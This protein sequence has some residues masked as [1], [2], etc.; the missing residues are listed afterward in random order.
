MMLRPGQDYV[1][2]QGNV[3]LNT[4]WGL[5]HAERHGAADATVA[6]KAA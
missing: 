2:H 6:I 1:D 3:G 4:P 5:H